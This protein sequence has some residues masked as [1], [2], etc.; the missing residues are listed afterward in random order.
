MRSMRI[1]ELWDWD[2][3]GIGQLEYTL[4]VLGE[5]LS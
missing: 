3:R 1:E 2:F 5:L 4:V